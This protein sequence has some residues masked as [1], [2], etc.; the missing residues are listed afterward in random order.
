[1]HIFSREDLAGS[2]HD[3]TEQRR[4]R[5]VQNAHSTFKYNTF[6]N[7]FIFVMIGVANDYKYLKLPFGLIT[8]NARFIIILKKVR[9]VKKEH[10]N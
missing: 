9:N 1:L 2:L 3:L 8:T 4:Q 10:R 7:L 5:L 6:Y